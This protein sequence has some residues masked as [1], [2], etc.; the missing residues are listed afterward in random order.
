MYFRGIL[1]VAA[2]GLR[3]VSSPWF[4]TLQLLVVTGTDLIPPCFTVR[5]IDRQQ[6]WNKS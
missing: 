4:S 3:S 2:P 6:S 1:H 5:G